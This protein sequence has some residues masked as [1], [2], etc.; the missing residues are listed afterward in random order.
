MQ[1]LC[2]A[3]MT[4]RFL[5]SLMFSAAI[6][7][8]IGSV[9]EAANMNY[10]GDWS[11]ALSYKPGSVVIYNNGIYYSLK[12]TRAAPNRNFTPSTNPSW[13]KQVGTVGNTIGDVPV[14][15]EIRSEVG[16]ALLEP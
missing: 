13:W 9:A 6:V 16:V 4:T 10:V 14:D 1:F 2:E 15:V 11:N 7:C 5:N 8:S 12:S 3:S